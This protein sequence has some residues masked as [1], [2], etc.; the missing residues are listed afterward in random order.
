MPA[1]GSLA[2][3]RIRQETAGLDADGAWRILGFLSWD[4]SVELRGFEPR[5]EPGEMALEL[6]FLPFGA[7]TAGRGSA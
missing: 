2:R 6:R 3:T 7:V 5:P 1:C 4:F